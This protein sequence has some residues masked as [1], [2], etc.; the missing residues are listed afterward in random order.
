VEKLGAGIAVWNPLE[1]QRK[2]F[3]KGSGPEGTEYPHFRID[4]LLWKL[5]LARQLLGAEAS[6][7]HFYGRILG[8]INHG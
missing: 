8:V 6:G 4:P 7:P 3:S 2:V 1:S 5:P